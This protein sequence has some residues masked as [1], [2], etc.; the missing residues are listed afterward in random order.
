VETGPSALPTLGRLLNVC[1]EWRRQISFACASRFSTS[2][3]A[4]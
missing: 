2:S 1:A 4:L 3:D